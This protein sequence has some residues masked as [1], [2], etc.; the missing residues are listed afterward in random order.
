MEL[1]DIRDEEGRP[2]GRIKDREEIHRDGDLHATSHVW[3]VDNQKDS[4]RILLQKRSMDKDAY[5]GCY[6]I[7]SAG[8][9]PAGE[10]YLSSA[11]REM[12]EELG[13][14]AMAGDL[15]LIGQVRYHFIREFHGKIFNNYEIS[16]V[17]IYQKPV[18]IANLTLQEEEVEEVRWM[19]LDECMERV[20]AGD[21]RFC[22][23]TE[24]L[25]MIRDYWKS[26]D[27]SEKDGE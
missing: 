1:I 23:M 19:D 27:Y 13:V 21:D 5:P 7:S 3:I 14:E 22:V 26:I 15:T 4:C 9:I 6:D 8:H 12:K 11:L 10:D 17:F 18:E 25:E 16:Q 24:E 20:R 2:T